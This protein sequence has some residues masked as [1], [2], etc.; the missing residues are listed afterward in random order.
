MV[1]LERPDNES[2]CATGGNDF[3]I[4]TERKTADSTILVS[5]KFVLKLNAIYVPNLDEAILTAC[6]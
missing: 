6:S 5:M 1:V 2:V 3:V 4:R